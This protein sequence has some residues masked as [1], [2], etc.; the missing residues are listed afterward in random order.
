M[1]ELLIY[2]A[3][4]ATP[5]TLNYLLGLYQDYK[6]DQEDRHGDK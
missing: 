4:F 6:E 3:G 1:K 2:I 5:F